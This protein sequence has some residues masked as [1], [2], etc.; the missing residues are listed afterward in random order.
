MVAAVRGNAATSPSAKLK[1]MLA[2]TWLCGFEPPPPPPPPPPPLPPPPPQA[3]RRQAKAAND[4]NRI[5]FSI[6]PVRPEK[7]AQQP[8]PDQQLAS[9]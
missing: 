5:S 1:L 8:L 6:F 7:S 9:Q 4:I 2:G 3:D